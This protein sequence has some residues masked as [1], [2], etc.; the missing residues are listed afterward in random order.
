MEEAVESGYQPEMNYGDRSSLRAQRSNPT[1]SWLW[2]VR[3]Y[4]P[5]ND[6]ADSAKVVMR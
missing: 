6:V 4:A 3:R 2:I 5:R 1:L